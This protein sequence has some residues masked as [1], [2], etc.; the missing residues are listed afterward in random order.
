[1]L[2]FGGVDAAGGVDDAA[3]GGDWTESV[4]VRENGGESRGEAQTTRTLHRMLNHHQLEGRQL[5][6][7]LVLG[8][9]LFLSFEKVVEAVDDTGSA[10]GGV[11]EAEFISASCMEVRRS[12]RQIKEEH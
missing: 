1:M 5:G 3:G 12:A 2:V 10:A 6:Q 4:Y 8:V 9:V 7:S 11:E